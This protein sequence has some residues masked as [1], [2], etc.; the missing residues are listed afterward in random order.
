ML[1]PADVERREQAERIS[2]KLA[3][4]READKPKVDFVDRYVETSSTLGLS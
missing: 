2:K 4:A 1:A 3:A